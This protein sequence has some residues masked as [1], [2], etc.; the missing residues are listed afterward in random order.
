MSKQKRCGYCR[1][2]RRSNFESVGRGDLIVINGGQ[3]IPV[4][5]IIHDGV[6]RIDEDK[7]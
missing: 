1:V 4:D 2:I 5:G 3:M 6:A 7:E